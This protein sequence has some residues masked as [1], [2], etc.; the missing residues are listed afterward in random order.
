MHIYIIFHVYSYYFTWTD[1]TCSLNNLMGQWDLTHDLS[2]LWV[3]MTYLT[4]L[5]V[6][7]S[8]TED[9]LQSWYFISYCSCTACAIYI[10]TMS[11][12]INLSLNFMKSIVHHLFSPPWHLQD[13]VFLNEHTFILYAFSFPIL[14]FPYTC[15][16]CIVYI[17]Y[18]TVVKTDAGRNMSWWR[19]LSKLVVCFYSLSLF[20][21]AAVMS[22]KDDAGCLWFCMWSLFESKWICVNFSCTRWHFMML[23]KN[24]SNQYH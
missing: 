3:L 21:F 14:S 11:F 22:V 13:D 4:H 8:V 15:P 6:L 5:F 1:C 24:R 7:S 2:D 17:I 18:L 19:P 16:T 12:P 9:A 10:W 20:Y 23:V